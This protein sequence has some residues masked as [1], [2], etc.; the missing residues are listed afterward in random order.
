VRLFQLCTSAFST[1]YQKIAY[2]STQAGFIHLVKTGIYSEY[3]REL[4]S[5]NWQLPLFLLLMP[6]PMPT[7]NGQVIVLVWAA[8]IGLLVALVWLKLP[9]G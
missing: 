5:S 2:P 1:N 3:L 8:L 7:R 6:G 4:F 9:L